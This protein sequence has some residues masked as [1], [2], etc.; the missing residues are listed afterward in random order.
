MKH[1]IDVSSENGV[2]DWDEVAGQIEFAILRFGYIGNRHNHEMDS[3]FER[4]FAECKRLGIPVGAYIYSNAESDEAI[5]D[6]AD[7]F[8]ENTPDKHFELPIF[9]DLEDGQ[10]AYLDKETQTYNAIQFCNYIE[11]NS[12]CQSGVYA[13]LNW[14]ENHLDTYMLSDFAILRWIAQ[15]G[16]NESKYDNSEYIMLQY[17][18]SGHIDGIDGNVDL[19]VLYYELDEDNS[20]D[21]VVSENDI[22]IPYRYQNGSTTEEVYADIESQKEIGHLNPYENVACL[23]VFKNRAIVLYAVD[24]ENNYKIGFVKWLGGIK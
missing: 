9:L 20:D 12:D 6:G 15:Y 16:V 1:G 21:E 2:I 8:L 7:W 14:Y 18:S 10:I 24:N 3:Q 17:T 11:N 23:G 4:N 13:N 19:N 5:I 22:V